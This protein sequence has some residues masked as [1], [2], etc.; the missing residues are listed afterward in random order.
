MIEVKTP[1]S[2]HIEAFHLLI[3]SDEYK[4]KI[5]SHWKIEVIGLEGYTNIIWIILLKIKL[6][7]YI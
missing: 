2:S 7:I 6:K 4:G 1:Q 3:Y 5:I